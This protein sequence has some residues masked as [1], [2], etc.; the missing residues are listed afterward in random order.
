MYFYILILLFLIFRASK[1]DHVLLWRNYS[2]PLKHDELITEKCSSYV[3]RANLAG[4]Y[5]I[6]EIVDETR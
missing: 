5:I 1:T 3:S 2:F 4:A 6:I